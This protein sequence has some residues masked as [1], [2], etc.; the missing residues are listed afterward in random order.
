[1]ARALAPAVVLVLSSC[2]SGDE[3]AELAG[4]APTTSAVVTTEQAADTTATSTPSTTGRAV[5]RSTS[6]PP[7]TRATGGRGDTGPPPMSY[8]PTVPPDV[9]SAPLKIPPITQ[10]QGLPMAS[11]MPEIVRLIS[12]GCGTPTPCVT[13]VTAVGD[14]DILTR[15]EFDR[16]EPAPETLVPRGSTVTVVV[17]SEPCD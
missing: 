9:P 15:C 14:N 7:V 13:I 5:T 2:A 4:V 3:A 11:V 1:M 6:S 16:I 8:D 12:Q 17:G 10:K